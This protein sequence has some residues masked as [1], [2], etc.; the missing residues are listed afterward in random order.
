MVHY[1]KFDDI[2]SIGHARISSNES[3]SVIIRQI[4]WFKK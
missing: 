4:E 2:N 1:F 3:S